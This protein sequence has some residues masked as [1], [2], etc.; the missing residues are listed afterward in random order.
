MV[1]VSSDLR[2]YYAPEVEVALVS[3]LWRHPEHLGQVLRELDLNLHFVQ[4]HCRRILE[5]IAIVYSDLG[6]VDWPFV[7][8]ALREQHLLDAVGNLQLVDEVYRY[9]ACGSLFFE[10]IAL[11][12]SYAQQRATDPTQPLIRFTGGS[13][14]LQWNRNKKRET[15]PDCIGPV[16]VRGHAYTVRGWVAEGGLLLN[17]K[18]YPQA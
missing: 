9:D 17:L 5:A 15:D 6:A 14:Q 4:W 8:Q 7:V 10:Y 12:K 13:G 3:F 1:G 16:R 18:F 2:T 11:L